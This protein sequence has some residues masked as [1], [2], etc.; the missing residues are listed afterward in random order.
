[1]RAF[2]DLNPRAA[3]GIDGVT[4]QEYD[5]DLRENLRDLR[6]RVQSGRY[7]ASL[8]RRVYIHGLSPSKRPG[9]RFSSFIHPEDRTARVCSRAAVSSAVELECGA[10]GGLA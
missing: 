10:F 7:R 9:R 1:M 3:A 4:W 5:Q 8:S 6:G 2:E